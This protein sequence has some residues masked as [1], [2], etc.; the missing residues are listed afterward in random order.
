[1]DGDR[2]ALLRTRAERL[3]LD[4]ATLTAR[5]L[6]ASARRLLDLA[7]EPV[8]VGAAA[9]IDP[10]ARDL[11]ARLV[12]GGVLRARQVAVTVALAALLAGVTL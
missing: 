7:A 6:S 11:A 10:G 5:P 2:F 12:A 9:A 4:R 1:V 8:R 3:L